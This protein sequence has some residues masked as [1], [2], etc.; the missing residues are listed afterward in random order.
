MRGLFAA[1]AV[2]AVLVF[3]PI[4][5][6]LATLPPAAEAD[7]AARTTSTP[8]RASDSA[9]NTVDAIK[10]AVTAW[11]SASDEAKDAA[12]SSSAVSADAI[13]ATLDRS[14]TDNALPLDFFLRLIWQESR[15]NVFSVSHA[16]AQGIAQFMPATARRV[17]LADPFDPIQALPKSAELLRQLRAQ[18]GN[19][20]LAAAAYNAG[21]KRVED[22]LAKRRVLPQETEA[23]VRIVTGRP[24]QDWTSAEAGAWDIAAPAPGPCPQLAKPVRDRARPRPVILAR[25]ADRPSRRAVNEQ[26][27]PTDTQH[28]SRAVL[29]AQRE[30]IRCCRLAPHGD[31]AARSQSVTPDR[32]TVRCCKT[33]PRN[34]KLARVDANVARSEA[35]IARLNATAP[36][37]I[38]AVPKNPAPRAH[39]TGSSAESGSA[40]APRSVR[41]DPRVGVHRKPASTARSA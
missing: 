15:F 25:K 31:H 7:V 33:P 3:V 22:W 32:E 5:A 20:G 13:C 14:A 17:G 36:K 10:A 24:A 18:F 23:Y 2:A 28:S 30:T 16:G 34:V 1:T 37:S 26:P 38:I 40:E 29:I 9:R 21:P 41:H 6:K 19:L 39:Q 12:S 35:K 4:E 11:F 27:G 8:D